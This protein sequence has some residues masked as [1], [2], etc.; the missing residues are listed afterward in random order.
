MEQKASGGGNKVTETKEVTYLE[1][2]DLLSGI[3]ITEEDFE[4][5][6]VG[7]VRLRG[8]TAKQG[9]E[10]LRGM[11]KD[12]MM[13]FQKIILMGVLRPKMTDADLAL[14]ADGKIGVVQSLATKIMDMSGMPVNEDEANAAVDDF[15]EKAPSES[16]SS[17]TASKSSTDSPAS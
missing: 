14:L 9:V 5:E 13:R 6:G 2:K 16:L 3:A 7:T 1:S 10:G 4:I 12:P 11:D 8:L 15:L 17:S